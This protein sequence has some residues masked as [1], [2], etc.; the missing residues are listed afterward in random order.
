MTRVS[1]VRCRANWVSTKFASTPSRLGF[2]ISDSVV[3][4]IEHHERWRHIIVAGRAMK[5]EML[6]EDLRGAI[7][8]LS[9]PRAISLP[10]RRFRFAVDQ[11]I[12]S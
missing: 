4:N 10:A 9:S 11:S 5:R 6:P 1:L 12:P 7:M 3:E 8:F 2:T